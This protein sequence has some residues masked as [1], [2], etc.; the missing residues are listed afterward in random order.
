MP[1]IPL[2]EMKPGQSGTITAIAGGQGLRAR[3]Q[4]L[5]ITSLGT[6]LVLA[7]F[8]PVASWGWFFF[9]PNLFARQF[10]QKSLG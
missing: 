9:L 6:V 5:G 2:T 4:P 10:Q 7:Y 3:L 8:F 1:Q